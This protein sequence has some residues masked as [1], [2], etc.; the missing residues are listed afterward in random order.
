MVSFSHFE[1]GFVCCPVVPRGLHSCQPTA[2]PLSLQPRIFFLNLRVYACVVH[3][4]RFSPRPVEVVR[5][6]GTGGTSGCELPDLGTESW[7]SERIANTLNHG[8]I[9]LTLDIFKN[10]GTLVCVCVCGD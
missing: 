9:S 4:Y 2:L 1:I 7:S 6:L 10:I 5:F 3:E 8:A